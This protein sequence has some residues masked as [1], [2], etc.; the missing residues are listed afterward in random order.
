MQRLRIFFAGISSLA[1]LSF[2]GCSTDGPV[3]PDLNGTPTPPDPFEQ[4]QRLG[5]GVNLGNALEA[6]VEGEWGVTLQAYFFPLLKNAGFKSVRLP[7]RWSA[8]AADTAPYT[9]DPA[10]MSRVQW[11]VDQSLASNLAVV[12]NCHHYDQFMAAPQAEKPRLL[13]IWQ[14]IAMRFRDYPDDLMFELLNEPDIR[15][16]AEV[17]NQ[18]VQESI[19]AIRKSN[20]RRT[21]I[22]GGVYWNAI[23]ALASLELPVSDQNLIVAVHYYNPLQF[24][25]QGADWVPGS[26]TWLGTEWLGTDSEKKRIESDFDLAV[27]WSAQHQRPVHL[28][29]FGAYSKADMNSRAR[30]TAHVV[31]TA[32]ERKISFA[33]W[34]FCAGFGVYDKTKQDWNYPL[35]NALTQ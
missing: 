14:Q 20:P 11:A 23:E 4:N 3:A 30:W 28:G 2:F 22:V 25:H 24:T 32:R 9:I 31:K 1:L 27:Q 33:Y 35:F 17:W 29:E 8:H 5:R 26:D 13:A 16:T 10:F 19:D 12:V 6:P 18:V 7:I 15:V 34:E 21:I